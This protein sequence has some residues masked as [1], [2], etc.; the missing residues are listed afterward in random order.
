M[1]PPVSQALVFGVDTQFYWMPDMSS[2]SVE[3]LW[4]SRNVLKPPEKALGAWEVDF[5]TDDCRAFASFVL[6]SKN[7]VAPW[8]AC[9]ASPSGAKG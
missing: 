7:Y 9:V 2:S 6:M 4:A 5:V 3:R 1:R 8:N